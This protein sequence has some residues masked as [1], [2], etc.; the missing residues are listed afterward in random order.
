MNGIE[1][2]AS[3]PELV[4]DHP[5][6]LRLFQELGV[7]FTCGGKSLRNACLERGL[8]PI[9]VAEECQKLLNAVVEKR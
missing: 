5:R 1:L 4:I 8:N 6:L 3:V 7:E 9:A 2:E